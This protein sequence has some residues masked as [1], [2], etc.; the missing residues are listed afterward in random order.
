MKNRTK[1]RRICA[2]Y[3]SRDSALTARRKKYCK[4]EDLLAEIPAGLP[5]DEAWDQISPVGR[6][7]GSSDYERL[8][9]LDARAGT[10]KAAFDAM[11]GESERDD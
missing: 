7:F 10:A 11:K 8:A 6:E 2:L 4:L 3:G 9:E 1:K 5:I